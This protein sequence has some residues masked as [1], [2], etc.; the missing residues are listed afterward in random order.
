[1]TLFFPKKEP[2]RVILLDHCFFSNTI[3]PLLNRLSS[4]LQ[5]GYLDDLTSGGPIDSV[6]RDVAEIREAGAEMGLVLNPVKCELI[7]HRDDAVSDQFVQS[8]SKVDIGDATLLGAP[9]FS[10]PVLV[11]TWSDRCDDLARAVDRLATLGSQDA[12]ILLR[13]SF[14]VPKVLHLLCCSPSVSHPSLGRFDS[15]LRSA[16][17]R[18]TNSDLSDTQ[19]LQASLPVRNGGLGVRHVASLAL[20]AFVASA[21]ST[22][23]LQDAILM[24]CA[25]S[26]YRT[27]KFF[28]LWSVTVEL[29]A[30][31]CS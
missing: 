11:K 3:H 29:V 30:A 17:E 9:L 13:S 26:N 4:Y 20:P 25:C 5:L 10:G 7:S 8:F 22:L 15:L 14:S 19:W 24:N 1:M 6:C 28:R 2:S 27:K 23:P 31:L 18:I 21:A 12:L 16:I